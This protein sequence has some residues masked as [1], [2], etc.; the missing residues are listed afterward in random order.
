MRQARCLLLGLVTLAAGRLH[1]VVISEIHYNPPIGDERLEF[2]ELANEFSTPEDISGYAF[3]NGID[4]TF[5]P[6]TILAGSGFLVVALDT[7]AVAQRYGITNVIGDYTGRLDASGERLTLVNHAGVVLQNIRFRDRGKWPGE[8]DGTGHTLSLRSVLLDSSEPESW[9]PSLEL[10]GTP[11][12]L[13]FPGE[14]ARFEESV[15]VDRGV[16]WRYAKGTQAYSSPPTA[17][18]AT[19]FDDSTWLEGPSGFG[20]GDGDDATDLPDMINTYAS[21]GIRKRFTLSPAEI[22][23]AGE[24]YLA[25]NYDD[26]F[27]AYL[28]EQEIARASCG[29]PGQDLPFDALATGAHEAGAEES[30][31][32]PRNLLVAG[33]NV[34]A[35]EGHNA[36]L[37]SSDLSLAPRLVRRRLIDPGPTGSR[38]R[39]VFN[40]LFRA[41]IAGQG[42][43]ELYNAGDT[44]VDLSAYKLTDD[45]DRLDPHPLPAGSIVAPHGFLVVHESETPLLLSTDEVHLYLLRPD[46]IAVAASAFDQAAPPGLVRGAYTELRFPDGGPL[47]W[48]SPTPSE[49]APNQVA[50]TSSIVI[51]EILY[52]PPERFDS[53]IPIESRLKG[54]FIELYNRG[55][56]AVDLSGFRFDKGIDYSFADGTSLAAGGYLVIAEDPSLME[57]RYGL[58][59]ALGPYAGKLANDGENIRLADRLG[60]L[61]DEVRYAEGGSWSRWADGGG[62]SLELIDA[63]QENSAATAWEGSDETAKTEWERLSFHVPTYTVAAESELHLYLVEAGVTLVDDVSI[64]Q[65]GTATN[66]IANPGFEGSTGGWTIE[67]THSRSRR[68]T[69]DKHS[70]AACLEISSSGK[71]DTLVNRI[72][73]ETSPALANGAAYDVALWARWQRG[74]SAIVVHGE[75]TAGPFAPGPGPSAN[76]S[77]NSIEAGLRLTVPL[78]IGTPGA[79]N[80][81]RARLRAQ[82]GSTNLGPVISE[83]SHKPPSPVANESVAVRAAVTDSGGIS[84]VRVYYADGSAA[85]PFSFVPMVDDGAHADGDAQDGVYGGEIPG[86]PGGARVVYYVEAADTTGAARRYPVD[87]PAKTCLYQVQGPRGPGMDLG[88]IVLDDAR[89]AEIGSRPLHSNELVDGAFVFNDEQ[90]YYNIGMRYRGSPWGRNGGNLRVRFPDDKPF[91]RGYKAVNFDSSGAA[92]NE[93]A[94]YFMISRNSGAGV[95]APSSYYGYSRI[96]VNGGDL[97]VR[98]LLQPIDRRFMSD[99]FGETEGGLILKV[100][101]RRAFTDQGTLANWE[102]ASFVYRGENE[103]D[104]RDYMIQQM[105]RSADEWQPW[106]NLT[107]VMDPLTSNA[108]AFDEQIDQILDVEEFLRAFSPRVLEGD[109]DAFCYGNGHNGAMIYSAVEGRWH[110]HGFDMDYSFQTTT[111]NLYGWSDPSAARLVSRPGPRRIYQRVLWELINGYWSSAV[112]GPFFNAVQRDTGVALPGLLGTIDA[113]GAAVRAEVQG[114]TT[115]AFRITTNGGRDISTNT[116][117]VQL[118]GTAPVQMASLYFQRNG[119]EAELLQPTWT[120]PTQWRATFDLPEAV[121]VFDLLGFDGTG[122]IVATTKIQV[123]TS[124]RPP[125]PVVALIFPTTGSTYG[126]TFVT[127]TGSGFAPGMKILF[128]GREAT[129]VSVVGDDVVQ[130]STPAAAFPTPL[131]GKVDVELVVSAGSR[132]KVA[133]AYTYTGEGGFIRGDVTN[134]SIVDISDAVATLFMLF[135]GT[136]LVCQDSA[137]V[138]DNGAVNV[139]DVIAM[140]DFLFRAGLAPKA[141]FPARGE[142]LSAD[143]LACPN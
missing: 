126:G 78:D 12:V 13:N 21:V 38:P 97:G 37:G 46:G 48:V 24:F 43:I 16:L 127:C 5:P 31:A 30:F 23:E 32:V 9:A 22:A 79:E 112:A 90:V 3:S 143:S 47:E 1:G 67:G 93:G 85:N 130:C 60:N 36:S 75:W 50:R 105:R 33:T 28:N 118:Q 87:A 136:P 123:T 59:D 61:V 82:T 57:T 102:G 63:D 117:I 110:Y 132:T 92:P 128:G 141:P 25:I 104:Y 124:A 114:S 99:W 70:G 39:I 52:H 2:V 94:A 49:G 4:F 91:A 135:R 125:G 41:A 26:G 18:R 69:S 53:S 65:S 19:Q 131:D 29:S 139:T 129:D 101:G 73:T 74:A 100:E 142:D 56:Q 44:S 81:A 10:G 111:P 106:I 35:I 115:V 17:W 11:G 34:L 45:P 88:R 84:T 86:R 76:L 113:V 89:T 71:G 27:C 15:L 14:G 54:E 64:V 108:A 62:S 98:G 138:D 66:L 116:L 83:A 8:P 20:Y 55:P 137:D 77:G 80:S 58:T 51:N 121:N 122:Q 120:S 6:G 134:D 7:Q 40:E 96:T 103:N 109:W 140:L 68:V 95:P 133:K 42:W 72:E 107:N 119:G